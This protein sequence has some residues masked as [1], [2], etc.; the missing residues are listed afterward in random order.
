MTKSSDPNWH[1]YICLATAKYQLRPWKKYSGNPIIDQEKFG[2][3]C[4]VVKVEG[5]YYL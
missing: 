2:F 5:K 4:S 3:V 1:M